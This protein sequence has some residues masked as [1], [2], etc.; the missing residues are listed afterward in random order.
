VWRSKFTSNATLISLT[1]CDA[2]SAHTITEKSACQRGYLPHHCICRNPSLLCGQENGSGDVGASLEVLHSGLLINDDLQL[3][4][5]SVCCHMRT[6]I[7][8]RDVVGCERLRAC[9]DPCFFDE[10]GRDLRRLCSRIAA[11]RARWVE[12]GGEHPAGLEVCA[13]ERVRALQR[14][15][16]LRIARLKDDLSDR[17]LPAEGSERLGRAP[18]RGDR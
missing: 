4:V 15:L 1:V 10:A 12:M 9:A 18:A 6:L 11:S 7:V 5:V 16:G 17:Q 13:H 14:T 2:S 8:P 3:A